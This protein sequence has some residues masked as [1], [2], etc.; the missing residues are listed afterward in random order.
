M[1][2]GIGKSGK[3]GLSDKYIKRGIK[4]KPLIRL[5]EELMLEKIIGWVCEGK[6][7][8]IIVNLIQAASPKHLTPANLNTLRRTAMNRLIAIGSQDAEI[9]FNIHV[10]W[11]EEIFAYA[12]EIENTELK[13][14]ALR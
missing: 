1:P 3:K 7:G 6:K 12:N 11:Y 9:V 5:Q 10:G 14:R 8:S 4:A 2:Q 13:N